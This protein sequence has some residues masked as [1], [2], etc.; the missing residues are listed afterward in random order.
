MIAT[1]WELE[2]PK[3]PESDRKEREDEGT[4]ARIHAGGPEGWLVSLTF[5]PLFDLLRPSEFNPSQLRAL[6]RA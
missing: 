5:G 3:D 1:W 4:V 6:L 2:D